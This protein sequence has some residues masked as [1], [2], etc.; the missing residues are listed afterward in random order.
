MNHQLATDVTR[1]LAESGVQ[2]IIICA[3]ARNAPFVQILGNG[4]SELNVHH[5]FDE[6][7]AGFFALGRARRDQRPVAVVTTS[8][9]AAAELLPSAV[10]AF[11]SGVPLVLVTADR[12]K[13]YRGT[14]APQTIEQVGMFSH[15][16]PKAFD[17]DHIDQ[18]PSLKIL[19]HAPTHV[20]VCFT[21]PQRVMS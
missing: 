1:I 13:N 8:G 10:E 12:P 20:N 9:T 6:R 18:V 17:I 21:E 16:A 14:G 19:A 15:Y 2:D 11:Y 5:F 7:A 4:N 3:G